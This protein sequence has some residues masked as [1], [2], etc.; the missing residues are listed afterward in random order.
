[1]SATRPS[2]DPRGP[3]LIYRPPLSW[4]G[5][6][7]VRWLTAAGGWTFDLAKAVRF[8]TMD[9][10]RL[11]A[12]GRDGIWNTLL[13]ARELAAFFKGRRAAEVN[14]EQATPNPK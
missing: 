11:F 10:T 12:S 5:Q 7:R 6:G 3:W 1:M 2:P 8:E 13:E 9:E 14:H 4:D